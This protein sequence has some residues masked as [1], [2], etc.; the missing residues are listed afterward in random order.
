MDV[1]LIT[2]RDYEKKSN[3]TLGEKQTQSKPITPQQRAGG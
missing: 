1:K 3:R 2:T